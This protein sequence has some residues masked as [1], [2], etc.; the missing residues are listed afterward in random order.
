MI[1]KTIA[2]KE[3]L[4]IKFNQDLYSVKRKYDRVLLKLWTGSGLETVSCDFLIWAAPMKE[5]LRTVSDATHQEWSLFKGLT[6]EIFSGSLANVK[7]AVKNFIYN[8]YLPNLNSETAVEHGVTFCGNMRG[9]QVPDIETPE[10]LEEFKKNTLETLY[11]LQI[12]K[13]KTDEK[14]LHQ[15]FR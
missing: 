12:A 13:N 1:W 11:C 3:N 4:N 9:L 7:N 6:P 15:K 10:V 5:L 14:N 2:E 8:G